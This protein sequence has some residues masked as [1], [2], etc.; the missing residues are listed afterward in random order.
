MTQMWQ[1]NDWVPTSNVEE[2]RQPRLR[3][4]NKMA[5]NLY[6]VLGEQTITEYYR[7]IL[8]TPVVEQVRKRSC[9]L[10]T[11]KLI[12]HLTFWMIKSS[13]KM[14][15]SKPLPGVDHFSFFCGFFIVK[16]GNK[17]I[18]NSKGLKNNKIWIFVS[19]GFALVFFLEKKIR[20]VFLVPKVK[21][22]C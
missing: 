1:C 6:Q 17:F 12:P 15:G 18:V 9:F 13:I 4:N 21:L 8:A 2:V 7:G 14:F 16:F 22:S 20:C 3:S 5:I 11:S 19:F 10:C